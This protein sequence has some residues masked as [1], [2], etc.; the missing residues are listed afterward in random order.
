M[1]GLMLLSDPQ[2]E[3]MAYVRD[4]TKGFFLASAGKRGKVTTF[5][6]GI[7]G[8]FDLP[9]LSRRLADLADVPVPMPDAH[10]E[11]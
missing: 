4:D 6:K 1:S 3:H 11:F 7:E 10:V 5:A 9:S 8:P 2:T